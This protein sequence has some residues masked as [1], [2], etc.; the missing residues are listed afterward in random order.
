VPLARLRDARSKAE[1]QEF[2]TKADVTVG[3][4]PVSAVRLTESVLTNDGP[5]YETVTAFPL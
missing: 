5:V 3:R 4:H 1:V 2:V